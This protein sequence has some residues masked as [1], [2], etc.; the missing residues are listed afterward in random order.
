MLCKIQ[1]K[2][3][4]RFGSTPVFKRCL[5]NVRYHDTRKQGQCRCVVRFHGIL[6]FQLTESMGIGVSLLALCL[7]ERPTLPNEMIAHLMSGETAALRR[8]NPAYVCLGSNASVDLS[9]YV[10]FTPDSGRIAATQR[11]DALGPS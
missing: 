10:G 7:S 4:D 9:W 11:T 6:P 2:T 1:N 8:F 5:L 3:Y